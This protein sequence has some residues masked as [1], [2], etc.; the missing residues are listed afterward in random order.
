MGD[1]RNRTAFAGRQLLAREVRGQQIAGRHVL[2]RQN[3]VQRL[4]RK[5]PPAVQE[6]RQMRLPKAGLAR[7]QGDADGPPLY[8]AQQFQAEPLMHLGKVHL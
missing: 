2:R 3:P 6:I 4:Q 8:P 7:Q 1:D 5:L